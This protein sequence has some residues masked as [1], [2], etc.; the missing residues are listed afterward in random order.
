MNPAILIRAPVDNS[1]ER[2]IAGIRDLS[3]TLEISE[4]SGPRC[5]GP[6]RGSALLSVSTHKYP[7]RLVVKLHSMSHVR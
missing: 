5:H 4:K 7:V 1:V 3:L 2:S 6:S